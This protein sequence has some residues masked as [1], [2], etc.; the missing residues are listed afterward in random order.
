MCLYQEEKVMGLK[1]FCIGNQG[2]M[3]LILEHLSNHEVNIVGLCTRRYGVVERLLRKIILFLKT[4]KLY[5]FKSFDYSS[6]ID[7]TPSIISIA[8]S[9][10]IPVFFSENLSNPLFLKKLKKLEIDVIIVSGFHKIIKQEI[11]QL[12]KIGIFNIHPSLL[13]KYRGGTPN[14]WAIRNGEKVTGVTV[15]RLTEKIDAGEVYLSKKIH[16]EEEFSWG[17]LE[18]KSMFAR[19]DIALEFIDLVSRFGRDI[20]GTQQNEL[21]ATYDP[22]YN[23]QFLLVNF[24]KKYEDIKRQLLAIY[25]KSGVFI[26]INNTYLCIYEFD[27]INFEMDKKFKD[28]KVGSVLLCG[29][30]ILVKF[31]DWCMKVTKIIWKGSIIKPRIVAHKYQL[32]TITLHRN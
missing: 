12:P 19:R 28:L 13:P 32:N 30:V 1:V 9:N 7:K 29:D 15:H 2:P 25:P 3:S 17:D 22:P 21:L 31:Q 8:K 23:N 5:P 20:K 16:I 27:K 26:K 10:K 24:E 6:P 4:N 14:R 11:I 18:I